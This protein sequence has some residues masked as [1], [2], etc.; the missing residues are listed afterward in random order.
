[1]G[2]KG[3]AITVGFRVKEQTD[4][5]RNKTGE[6]YRVRVSFLFVCSSNQAFFF[7][8]PCPADFHDDPRL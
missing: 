3:F 7:F 8:T 4:A 5:K 6:E 2:K 1:M